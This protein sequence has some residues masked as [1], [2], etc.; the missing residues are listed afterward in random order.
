MGKCANTIIQIDKFDVVFRGIGMP[1][2]QNLLFALQFLLF[3][4]LIFNA[5]IFPPLLKDTKYN[6][7]N[8]FVIML[9]V[10]MI[11]VKIGLLTLVLSNASVRLSNFRHFRLN[12][13]NQ[14]SQV[15]KILV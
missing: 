8:S 1:S 6:F 10:K 13:A 14:T 2:E 12:F 15:S 5:N 9:N 7:V 11:L 4:K 3:V